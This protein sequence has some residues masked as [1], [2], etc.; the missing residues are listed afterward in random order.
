MGKIEVRQIPNELHPSGDHLLKIMWDDKEPPKEYIWAKGEDE[1]FRW[2]G[3]QWVPYEFELIE[4]KGCAKKNCG[5]INKEELAV[6]LDKFKQDVLTAVLRMNQSQD[7]T[8]ISDIREQI[9]KFKVI[10][11]RLQELEDYYTKAEIDQKTSEINNTT[12]VLNGSVSAISRRVTGLESNLSDILPIVNRLNS[13]DHSQFLTEVS[14]DQ[15][16]TKE[17]VAEQIQEVTNEGLENRISD[18]EDSLDDYAT[19]AELN[20]FVSKN[21]LE[22]SVSNAGFLKADANA[23]S[24]L[25]GSLANV[26]SRV[27]VLENKPDND[28]IYDDTELR[29]YITALRTRVNTLE[30]FPHLDY[31]TTE[32]VPGKTDEV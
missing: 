18:L 26:S 6:K 20:G 17:D 25:N 23:I 14:M 15:Y 5:F 1:Y 9:A 31:I 7:A 28:T 3:K 24:D 16:A 21:E 19:L 10:I 11:N 8:N 2:N 22:T 30:A 12:S 32:D 27:T 29:D 4:N 13:I